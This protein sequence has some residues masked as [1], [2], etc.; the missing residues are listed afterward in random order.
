MGAREGMGEVILGGGGWREGKGEGL[1]QEGL[2]M[3]AASF[4]DPTPNAW[5]GSPTQGF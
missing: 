2:E 5:L 1:A 3:V 4:A